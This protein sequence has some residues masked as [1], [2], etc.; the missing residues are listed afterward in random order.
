[1]T[2]VS[3][4]SIIKPLHQLVRN[5]KNNDH[6]FIMSMFS[7]DISNN[8]REDL[9]ILFRREYNNYKLYY[10]MQS[11]V[12][13]NVQNIKN[14]NVRNSVHVESKS[15]SEIYNNILKSGRFSYKVTINPSKYNE[16][17]K[18]VAVRGQENIIS[19]WNEKSKDNGFTIDTEK[20]SITIDKDVTV[21]NFKIGSSTITGL[22][23]VD[24]LEL[25]NNAIKNGIG[26]NKSY[27]F[28]LILIGSYS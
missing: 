7:D 3:K 24:N 13:P 5:D 8:P 16:N 15:I 12:V 1:M 20:T 25:L 22:A 9:N 11:S 4:I 19:W 28:G 27:G 26:R 10:L 17:K 2:Y 14:D 23:T 21:K 18:R 6:K